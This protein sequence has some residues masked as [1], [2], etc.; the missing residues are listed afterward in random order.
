MQSHG[1]YHRIYWI[2]TCI[3]TH[4][5]AILSYRQG[6]EPVIDYMLC[7]GICPV[8][9]IGYDRIIPCNKLYTD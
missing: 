8:G 9:H 7:R 4:V 3:P 6:A 1:V 5:N 2:A